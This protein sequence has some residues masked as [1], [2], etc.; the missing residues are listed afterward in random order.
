M[1][2]LKH[3]L[4]SYLKM[5]IHANFSNFSLKKICFSRNLN[6][7]KAISYVFLLFPSVNFANYKEGFLHDYAYF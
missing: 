1:D 4:C 7:E 3:S 6:R 5:P 2:N